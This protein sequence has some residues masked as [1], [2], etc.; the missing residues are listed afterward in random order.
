MR[1]CPDR[2]AVRMVIF[3]TSPLKARDLRL[4]FEQKASF[5]DGHDEP[6]QKCRLRARTSLPE[7]DKARADEK[8]EHTYE[9][10]NT[11]PNLRIRGLS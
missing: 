11:S 5:M 3:L 1:V 6:P 7:A 9:Y 8:G 10:E 2:F 4:D